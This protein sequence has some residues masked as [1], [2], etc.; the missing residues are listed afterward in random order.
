MRPKLTGKP[1]HDQLVVSHILVYIVRD[2]EKT[3]RSSVYATLGIQGFASVFLLMR[4]VDSNETISFALG[5]G[6][7]D[8][9]HTRA[10]IACAE[11]G[12]KKF[13]SFV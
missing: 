11:I 12:T 4:M 1:T 5:V 9:E 13:D 2:P 8:E 7:L 10:F 3:F 6:K